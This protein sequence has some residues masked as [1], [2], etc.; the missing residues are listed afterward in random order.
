MRIIGYYPESEVLVRHFEASG[1]FRPGDVI[2]PVAELGRVA[3]VASEIV[4]VGR[5]AN[6]HHEDIAHIQMVKEIRG[7]SS[8]EGLTLVC[9]DW[10][11]DLDNEP[12]GTTLTSGSWVSYGLENGLFENAY[13][14]GANCRNDSE[15][16]PATGEV[17]SDGMLLRLFGRVRL[18]TATGGS[19]CLKYD[20]AF[21]AALATN[22]CVDRY[23]VS[24]DESAV[25][26]TYRSVEAVDYR[27]L[28]ENVFVSID[29]DVLSKSEVRSDCPQGI[30]ATVDLLEAINDLSHRTRVVG[31]A[32]C[33][34]D[35]VGPPLD[36]TSLD[37]VSSVIGS[38][39]CRN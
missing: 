32:I 29:L 11:N 31:W 22:P 35:L 28:R 23:C 12:D 27:D 8:R 37:T 1:H 17:L 34:A 33:G 24:E 25:Q 3:S 20:R 13:I 19:T 6:T 7:I 10:H 39:T 30:W 14:L 15:V 36:D 4:F 16:N 21:E 5:H 26:V 2:V 9:F 38:C 18:F